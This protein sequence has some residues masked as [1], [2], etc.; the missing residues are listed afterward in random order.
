MP[1][2]LILLCLLLLAPACG[3][4]SAEPL[5]Y[6]G[7]EATVLAF[8][9]SLTH[10][11]GATPETAYPAVLQELIQRRVHNVSTPGDRTADGLEKLPAAL[12]RW[13]PDLLIL[14]LGGNDFLRKVDPAQTLRNLE[15]MV[16]LARQN[17]VAVLLLGV[18]RPGLF[19]LKGDEI[20]RQLAKK[21]G[22]ALDNDSLA[23]ILADRKLKSDP[24]H[25]NA[26]GYRR[27]AQSISR[28]L[29]EAG[30]I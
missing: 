10:G 9:D 8:G 11:T 24:I 1:K 12:E 18:P 16:T 21:H 17:N 14:C 19:G 30:A 3:R 28:Y 22:L 6:L 23:D 7:R 15:E 13:Q 26:E 2:G 27:L 5:P 25:P 4:Q 20:Y 29:L